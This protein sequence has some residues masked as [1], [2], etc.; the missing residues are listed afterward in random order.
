M[1][2]NYITNM[3]VL[4]SIATIIGLFIFYLYDKFEKKQY[5][6]AEYFRIGILIFISCLATINISRLE[7]FQSGSGIINSNNS[8]PNLNNNSDSNFSPNSSADFSSINI[9]I[10]DNEND[11][12]LNPITIPIENNIPFNNQPR[13][14]AR[15]TSRTSYRNENTNRNYSQSDIHK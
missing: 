9:N 1:F 15:T 8:S 12:Q 10:N 4:S 6:N 14:T 5:T 3:Y 11:I 13:N 2:L 7:F